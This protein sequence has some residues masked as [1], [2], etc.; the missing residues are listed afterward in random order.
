MSTPMV[1]SSDGLNGFPSYFSDRLDF[2]TPLLPNVIKCTVSSVLA[3][4]AAM[5]VSAGESALHM[6]RVGGAQIPR[7]ALRTASGL[8]LGSE[9]HM[10]VLLVLTAHAYVPF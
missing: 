5:A 6:E 1:G 10:P 2:P 7:H 8:C 3:L 9:G 4:L